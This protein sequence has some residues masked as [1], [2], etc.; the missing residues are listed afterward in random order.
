MDHTAIPFHR[1]LLGQLMIVGVLPTT[2]VM[3]GIVAYNRWNSYTGMREEQERALVSTARLSA[4]VIEDTNNNILNLM[5]VVA[6]V[7]EAGMFGR[8][9]ETLAML[10]ALLRSNPDLIGI[11]VG[12]EP[13]ADGK[14]AASLA[15]PSLPRESMDAAGRF[16]PYMWRDWSAGDRISM[17]NL[18]NMSTSLYYGG[19][20]ARWETQ[21]A[22]APRCT[23]PYAY[24]GQFIVEQAAPII[25]DGD[26]KGMA[27]ADRSLRLVDRMLR[28]VAA[29]ADVDA[30]LISSGSD[31][32]G[33]ESG[34]AFIAA[35]TDPLRADETDVNGLLRTTSVERSPYSRVVRDLFAGDGDAAI[36]VMPDPVDGVECYFVGV[37][38]RS[39]GWRLML[40]KPVHE[41]TAPLH[42]QTLSSASIA[43]VGLASVAMLLTVPAIRASRRIRR[44]V[45][46]AERIAAGDL[47]VRDVPSGRGDEADALLH[48]LAQTSAGLE[49]IV[50]RVKQTTIQVNSTATQLSATAREQEAGAQSLGAST[51][52][53][54]AAVQEI[55]STSSEL[56]RT[57]E[58][59]D[60][61]ASETG[62][63][64]Q[65]GRTGLDA[66]GSTMASLDAGTQSIAGKLAT[67]SDKASTINS[68]V[69]TISKVAD[70]TNLLSVN[71]AIEAEKAGEHG[72][73]FLVVAREIRRLADQTAAATLDIE[74]TV[75]QMQSAV[76]A[77]VMEMDR[78]N[79]QVRRGV[80]EVANVAAQLAEIIGQV[81][82]GT[83]QFSQV[84]A[85]MHA[86][87][88]GAAQI[89]AAMQ[90][91][92][93]GVREAVTA[94]QETCR[95][96][97]SLQ[98]SIAG[99]KSSVTAFRVREGG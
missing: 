88:Q 19:M 42:A 5:Q 53:I 52:Q 56:S 2:L 7:Q 47:A 14:D 9:A 54:A 26:F 65:A 64:A 24:D 12:Y 40:R 73:G 55:T 41:V 92:T 33:F 63:L 80:A 11:C 17:K 30:F 10:D 6:R 35:T 36:R 62:R 96:A 48:A 75:R 57:M 31:I 66:M 8:R 38:V 89:A 86:Q 93:A 58:R 99:L 13:N 59:V 69:T 71:A 79:E 16:I 83:S 84:T 1:R 77:G 50:A 44:A 28:D 49:S 61:A 34:P 90:Q 3:G 32:A 39:G 76:S 43:A 46:A 81:D 27:C 70:Q 21:G 78:F 45:G 68:V 29:N 15:D 51:S 82:A 25:I 67:I 72:V 98:E 4:A 74:E 87:S 23:E 18:T 37:G 95:C 91:F 20:K 22:R 60:Q 94:A 85:G 97:T